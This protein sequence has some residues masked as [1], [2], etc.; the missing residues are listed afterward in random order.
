[1]LNSADDISD[2]IIDNIIHNKIDTLTINYEFTKRKGESFDQQQYYD[3]VLKI[4]PFK[5][6]NKKI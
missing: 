5:R 4:N 2:E 6:A 1:M 3:E